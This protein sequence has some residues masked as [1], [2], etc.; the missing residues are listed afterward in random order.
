MK[1]GLRA[2][3]SRQAK[4]FAQRRWGKEA[5]ITLLGRKR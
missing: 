2:L 3:N 1:V 4:G 5:Q